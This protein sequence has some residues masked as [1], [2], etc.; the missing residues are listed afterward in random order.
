MLIYEYT[1]YPMNS[2]Y[3]TVSQYLFF[4]E[5]IVPSNNSQTQ[6]RH[7]AWIKSHME[8]T[9]NSNGTS[10][11]NMN[12]IIF[13]Y[14]HKFRKKQMVVF[15]VEP[16]WLSKQNIHWFSAFTNNNLQFRKSYKSRKLLCILCH[17]HVWTGF[18]LYTTLCTNCIWKGLG[19]R[20]RVSITFHASISNSYRD[21]ANKNNRLNLRMICKNV[22]LH[23]TKCYD[24]LHLR[25][26]CLF[27]QRAF[28]IDF[29]THCWR[30]KPKQEEVVPLGG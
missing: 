7:V 14:L 17:V 15:N 12:L 20:A 21:K 23:T 24:I 18:I 30:H 16:S 8:Y 13:S 4:V 6:K 11:C 5:F 1:W 2:T 29:A 26:N 3:T 28:N 9:F 22:L 19:V 25:V 27:R 10:P